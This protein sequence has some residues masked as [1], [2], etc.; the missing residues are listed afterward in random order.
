MAEIACVHDLEPVVR[1]VADIV[2]ADDHSAKTPGPVATSTWIR[3]SLVRDIPAVIADAFSEADRRD[4][5]RERT[6]I[7]LVDGNCT[8]IEAITA[9]AVARGK[10]VPILIDYLHVAG[11]VWDAAKSRVR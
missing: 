8:Q 2:S 3:A 4:P 11:Y 10:Q 9:Q 6:W 7:A 5:G 1:T